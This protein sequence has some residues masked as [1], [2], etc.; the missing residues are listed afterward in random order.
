M[1]LIVWAKGGE[2]I[3]MFGQGESEV[4]GDTSNWKCLVAAGTGF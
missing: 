2:E 4:L 3:G 1:K